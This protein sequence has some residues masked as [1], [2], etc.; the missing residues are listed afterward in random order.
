MAELSLEPYAARLVWR[1]EQPQPLTTWQDLLAALLDELGLACSTSDRHV[2]GHIKAFALLPAGGF[3]RGSKV[4]ACYPADVEAH[5]DWHASS[6]PPPAERASAR[7]TNH[8]PDQARSGHTELEMTLNMLV[9]GLPM[10][11]ARRM[12]K[13]TAV[14]QAARWNAEL[15]IF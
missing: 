4:T 12:V 13:A 7:D 9:Y 5:I 11:S 14:S 2:I 3:L 10:D 15:E 8:A 1:F 6:V